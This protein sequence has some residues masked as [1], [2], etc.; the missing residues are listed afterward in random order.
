MFEFLVGLFFIALGVGLACLDIATKAYSI[1][2]VNLITILC[3]VFWIALA[4]RRHT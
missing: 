1:A 2:P 4:M 3:G